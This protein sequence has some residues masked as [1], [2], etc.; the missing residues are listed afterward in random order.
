M[1]WYALI[2]TLLLS[3]AIHPASLVAEPLDVVSFSSL[4]KRSTSVVIGRCV[5]VTRVVNEDY[6]PDSF[7]KYIVTLRVACVFKGAETQTLR[8]VF[9][10]P[11]VGVPKMGNS[12]YS[13]ALGD[14]V[15]KKAGGLE[16]DERVEISDEVV[17]CLVFLKVQGDGLPLVPTTKDRLT[18]NSSFILDGHYSINFY[19]MELNGEMSFHQQGEAGEGEDYGTGVISSPKDEI[20]ER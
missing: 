14:E 16:L 18:S 3:L 12:P 15:S 19:D 13:L 7:G 20:S 2:I 1:R 4:K 6:F 5:S 8:F 9:H 17:Y 10:Q 11:L